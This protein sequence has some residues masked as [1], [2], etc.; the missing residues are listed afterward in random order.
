MNSFLSSFTTRLREDGW[1]WRHVSSLIPVSALIVVQVWPVLGC[2]DRA[3]LAT[4]DG[5]DALL[6]SG[7]LTWTARRFWDPVAWIGLP[8]FFP[9]SHAL[10]SMDP[11][12]GQAILVAPVLYLADPTPALLYNLAVIATL[13]LTAATGAALWLAG[14][15]GQRPGA[16]A[17]GAGLTALFLVGS[18]FTTWQLGLLNQI[19]PPWVV[20]L[21]VALW[22]GWRRFAG[23]VDGR[24]WW[25]LA[26]AC[27]VC[28]A[29]WGW[30]GFADAVFVLMTGAVCG[31][32]IAFR[33]RQVRRLARQT[34]LPA[35]VA[36]VLVLAIA[37]PYIRLRTEVPEYTRDLQAVQYYSTSLHGLGNPG[38]HR[39]TWAD[40]AGGGEPA[41]ERAMRN[42]DAVL[43]PGWL[44]LACAIL[45]AWRWRRLPA[46]WRQYG[47][48]VAAVGLVGL[49]MSFGD[50]GGLPPG[51]DRRV[52]LPFGILRELLVPFEAFRAPSRFV[53]LGTIALAWWACL[54]VY[55]ARRDPAPRRRRWLVAAVWTL[56]WLESVPIAMLAVPVGVDG[57][58]NRYPLPDGG[59]A[60]AVLS[61]P[62]PPTEADE[63]A[64][65]ALWL[66]R[67]LAT[68][69]PVTGGMSGWVPPVTRQLRARLADCEAGRQDL[70][71]LFDSLVTEGVTGAELAEVG[72]PPQR[73][74]FWRR[75]L[76]DRGYQGIAT[77]PGYRY[78]EL[79]R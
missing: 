55:G 52:I 19:S 39:W 7:I 43:H 68:G 67:A 31:A 11:L 41:A 17:A 51:S 34:A 56:V 22:R 58:E 70:S 45:G 78:Y 33:R 30:Y 53:Y 60:G 47:L 14:S 76:A 2:L 75:S 3:V 77:A 24:G 8:I 32:W 54:G 57:R 9:S 62:A 25:W 13:V 63:E 28:Q 61:L 29:A 5:G 6:Q 18:P 66:H 40:L 42:T 65:D 21:M 20:L 38:P 1:R 12:L 59:A 72:A 46:A 50:S 37:W 35:L 10:L 74:A 15:Q 48:F 49:V 36:A 71:A 79:T 27:L 69:R 4:L 16:R 64:F 73:V 44:T 23:G 26:S